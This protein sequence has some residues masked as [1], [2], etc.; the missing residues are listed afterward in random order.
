VP[1]DGQLFF[2]GEAASV[3]YAATVHGALMSGIRAAGEV[4]DVATDGSRV[5]VIGAGAAGLGAAGKPR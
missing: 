5:I 4:L 1:V 3:D 2:A